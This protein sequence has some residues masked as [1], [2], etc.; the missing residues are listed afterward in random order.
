MVRRTY[1]PTQSLSR[2]LPAEAGTGRL[3][4]VSSL[5]MVRTESSE[6]RGR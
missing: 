5:T 3:A 2:G 4:D 6:Q 1:G